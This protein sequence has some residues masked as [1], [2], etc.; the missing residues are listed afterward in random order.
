MS[1]PV[2][3][4]GFHFR[5]GLTSH[6]V[7]FLGSKVG[8]DGPEFALRI[9]SWP[10]DK[11]T[12]TTRSCRLAAPARV[13]AR[14]VVDVSLSGPI[15]QVS[16]A[17]QVIDVPLIDDCD[18]VCVLDGFQIAAQV[19]P[20]GWHLG[21]MGLEVAPSGPG[22]FRLRAEL[23]P[24]ESPHPGIFGLGVWSWDEPCAHDVSLRW[25]AIAVPQGALRVA[26]GGTTVASALGTTIVDWAP[27]MIPAGAEDACLLTGFRLRLDAP[28]KQ[29]R[30]SGYL[31]SLNGRYIR[32]LGVGIEGGQAVVHLSNAPRFL[33]RL[34]AVLG[35]YLLAAT[36]VLAIL[37]GTQ[38]AF[39]AAVL[40]VL[41][42]ATWA[43]PRIWFQAPAVPWALDVETSCAILEGVAAQPLDAR[44][45][46][47][48]RVSRPPPGAPTG[49][50]RAAPSPT[51]G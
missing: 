50:S 38:W 12:V 35:L 4:R 37:M 22:S 44:W 51:A 2:V 39:A 45:L 8:E 30:R 20:A 10:P 41:G 17:E 42:L 32:E 7:P 1:D 11:A 5:W 18:V 23:R 15:G 28:R 9:G 27:A 24:A 16:S 14:G 3:W 46:H 26:S 36:A 19:N 25:A 43:W 13:V 21:G 29:R 48:G 40:V 34:G 47:T 33:I 49:D 6:R 31:R